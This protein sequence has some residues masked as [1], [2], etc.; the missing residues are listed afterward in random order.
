MGTSHSCK[1][2]TGPPPSSTLLPSEILIHISSFLDPKSINAAGKTCHRWYAA[3]R[4]YRPVQ[5]AVCWLQDI[6]DSEMERTLAFMPYLPQRLSLIIPHKE[7]QD[8]RSPGRQD[9][10]A[11][12]SNAHR[13]TALDFS[14]Q[15][16][17]SS[18]PLAQ[19]QV[20]YRCVTLLEMSPLSQLVQLS[21]K[22][23][24]L[25]PVNMILERC[26]KL[27]ELN[28]GFRVMGAMNWDEDQYRG[29]SLPEPPLIQWLGHL[30]SL[31]TLRLQSMRLTGTDTMYTALD[32]I[33][34]QFYAH[35]SAACPSLRS[36]HISFD[37][38]RRQQPQTLD[39]LQTCF[40]CLQELSLG[41]TDLP[42]TWANML[43]QLFDRLYVSS[44]LTSFEITPSKYGPS[45]GG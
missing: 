30:P 43:P 33:H 41:S 36:L 2:S 28:I 19:E 8:G 1:G 32:T 39:H 40:S 18:S 5:Y 27:R 9:G 35:I 12:A 37:N 10:P 7:D 25:A 26:L 16:V 17:S 29:G 15:T 44:L 11:A 3:F 31:H 6:T 4:Q 13:L 20:Q 23:V 45:R 34:P 14:N 22:D 42:Q 21:L 24:Y 38:V